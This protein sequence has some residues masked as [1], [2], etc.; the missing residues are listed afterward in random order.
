MEADASP[1]SKPA[2]G[3][4]EKALTAPS[5]VARFQAIINGAQET[6]GAPGVSADDLRPGSWTAKAL[7]QQLF[8]EAIGRKA[9]ATDA[10]LKSL[11]EMKNGSMCYAALKAWACMHP[12]AVLNILGRKESDTIEDRYFSYLI[13]CIAG[14]SPHKAIAVL[15]T[16]PVAGHL[17]TAWDAVYVAIAEKDPAAALAA[18]QSGPPGTR[19]TGA[20]AIL[21]AMAPKDPQAALAWQK[22]LP[23][24]TQVFVRPDEVYKEWSKTEPAAA[25]KEWTATGRK[26][27]DGTG[28]ALLHEWA[29]EYPEAVFQ[30][31]VARGENGAKAVEI[32]ARV[33]ALRDPARAFA[34]LEHASADGREGLL[35]SIAEGKVQINAADALEW[36][37]SLPDESRQ[38]VLCSM[39]PHLDSLPLEERRALALE[40]GVAHP[41]AFRLLLETDPAE[42]EKTLA[43]MPPETARDIRMEMSGSLLEDSPAAA[44]RFAEEVIK[45]LAAPS[46]NVNKETPPPDID[47]ATPADDGSGDSS[48]D[49][50][51]E[52]ISEFT[53]HFVVEWTERDPS[54]AAEW[55]RS[56]PPGLPATTAAANLVLNWGRVDLPAAR[57]WVDQLPPGDARDK[58]TEQFKRFEEPSA[59]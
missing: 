23:P 47:P 12:D 31:A 57:A 32:A 45:S 4:L 24:S 7:A 42:A 58:A 22:S 29:K 30:W 1:K 53:A 54:A 17:Y 5:I 14:H 38:S 13:E 11:L 10:G 39:I 55:V 19:T 3:W 59:K 9:P 36:A 52:E 25:F 46:P 43:G 27:D 49:D 34:M 8:G 21:R 51:V 48:R 6:G 40:A 2:S 41:A 20:A 16:R 18:I 15:K 50:T 26:F 37:R 56:L 35:F 44:A 28:D 33:L